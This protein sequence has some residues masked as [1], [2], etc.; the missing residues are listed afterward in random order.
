[1]HI[2]LFIK[3]FTITNEEERK[4]NKNLI[5]SWITILNVYL[6]FINENHFLI[7]LGHLLNPYILKLLIN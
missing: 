3:L 1:M 4:S 5:Y 7:A 6:F 2:H